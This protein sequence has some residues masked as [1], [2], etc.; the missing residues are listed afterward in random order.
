MYKN[1]IS[2]PHP[3]GTGLIFCPSGTSRPPSGLE[4]RSTALG[5]PGS[6]L[7]AKNGPVPLG[8]GVEMP[9]FHLYQ[10]TIIAPSPPF[11]ALPSVLPPPVFVRSVLVL[12]SPIVALVDVRGGGGE[13][14][15]A[16]CRGAAS[17]RSGGLSGATET[18]AAW[19]CWRFDV[20]ISQRWREVT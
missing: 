8:W 12:H 6:A 2:T 20:L 9:Q 1:V 16:R 13:G 17:R 15:S 4:L 14:I 19:R 7:G 3:S 11:A 18:T 5:R 10:S